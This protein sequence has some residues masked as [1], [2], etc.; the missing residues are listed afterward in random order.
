M[1]DGL[2]DIPPHTIQLRFPSLFIAK[3]QWLVV[4]EPRQGQVTYGD[5]I[6]DMSLIAHNRHQ[7]TFIKS[8]LHA[9]EDSPDH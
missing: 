3:R 2:L 1:G 6:S 4:Q 7:P 5:Q 9:I 8:A